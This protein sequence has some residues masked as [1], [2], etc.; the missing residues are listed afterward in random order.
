MYIF[1][2]SSIY[3]KLPVDIKELVDNKI[4][5]QHKKNIHKYLIFDLHKFFYYNQYKYE[6]I[7]PCR[8]WVGE[9]DDEGFIFI[10]DGIFNILEMIRDI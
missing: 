8:D 5:E 4:A 6:N 3:N 10:E 9:W 7:F 1:I 2:M